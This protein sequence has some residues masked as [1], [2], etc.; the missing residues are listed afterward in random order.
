VI[1]TQS[2]SREARKENEARKLS[3][4]FR[5]GAPERLAKKTFRASQSSALRVKRF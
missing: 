5:C 2:V 3:V 4:G 1:E